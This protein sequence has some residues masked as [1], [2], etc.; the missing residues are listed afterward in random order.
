MNPEPSGNLLLCTYATI[1]ESERLF[2]SDAGLK[3]Q[4]EDGVWY[5]AGVIDLPLAAYL[6]G[7]R[8]RVVSLQYEQVPGTPTGKLISELE[9]ERTGEPGEDEAILRVPIV[10][11]LPSLTSLADETIYYWE[12]SFEDWV[13]R[14]PFVTTAAD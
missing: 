2:L 9:G 12:V 8:L 3:S 10:L 13:H 5:L 4:P 7:G 1:A 14:V 6:K 11:R